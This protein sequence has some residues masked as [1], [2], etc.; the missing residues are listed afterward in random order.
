MTI[1][2]NAQPDVTS[3][4][5]SGLVLASAIPVSGVFG[6]DFDELADPALE[7]DGKSPVSSVLESATALRV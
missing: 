1:S 4:V 5:T 7:P 3:K 2:A 6:A